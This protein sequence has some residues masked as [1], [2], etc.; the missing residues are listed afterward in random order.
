MTLSCL[1][2]MR[3]LPAL[4]EVD[5]SNHRGKPLKLWVTQTLPPC[6][7]YV[8]GV[9]LERTNPLELGMATSYSPL[10]NLTKVSP[11]FSGAR[12][13]KT[14]TWVYLLHDRLPLAHTSLGGLH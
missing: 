6:R 4:K 2:V 3:F 7:L 14:K 9:S 13:L 1:F 11:A 8:S 5:A 10:K 12:L